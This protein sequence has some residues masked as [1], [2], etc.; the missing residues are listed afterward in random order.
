MTAV[1]EFRL[2]LGAVL[3]ALGVITTLIAILGVYRFRFIM[4]RMHCAAMI[5]TLGIA[6]ILVGLM[7]LSGKTEYIPKLIA[8]LILLWIG[9]PIASHLVSRLEITT[10]ETAS[11][12]MRRDDK[13]GNPNG[14]H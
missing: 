4:N 12:H 3:L 13:E 7:V 14:D 9:S 2:I 10:D 11:E 5:D 8:L 1:T 6:L